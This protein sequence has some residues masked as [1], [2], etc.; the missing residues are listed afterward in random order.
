M[1]VGLD[2][3][4]KVS[5]KTYEELLKIPRIGQV[6]AAEITRKVHRTMRDTGK[7]TKGSLAAIMDLDLLVLALD[8]RAFRSLTNAGISTVGEL[9]ALDKKTLLTFK[10][11]GEKDLRTHR[12]SSPTLLEAER[13]G[14]IAIA[15]LGLDNRT[16]NALSKNGIFT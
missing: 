4:E 12:Q 11:I 3:L 16:L 7:P 9:I 1:S 5:S 14:D 6:T 2:T 10:G 13:E 15:N 8:R